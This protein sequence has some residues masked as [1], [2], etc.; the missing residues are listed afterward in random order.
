MDRGFSELWKELPIHRTYVFLVHHISRVQNSSSSGLI[1][2]QT[3]RATDQWFAFNDWVI[4]LNR[5]CDALTAIV[6]PYLNA[7]STQNFKS[8]TDSP[9]FKPIYKVRTGSV[10]KNIALLFPGVHFFEASLTFW[11]IAGNFVPGTCSPLKSQ[12]FPP[13][14]IVDTTLLK[15]LGRTLESQK[16]EC[17]QCTSGKLRPFVSY[18]RLC[19][20]CLHIRICRFSAHD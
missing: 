7:L 6:T 11:K 17:C 2:F 16:S 14:F 15:T 18:F 4:F 19:W 10:K 1:R 5:Y 8:Q 20:K 13:I 12:F 9:C 3:W